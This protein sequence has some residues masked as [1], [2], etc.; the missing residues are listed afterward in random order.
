MVQRSGQWLRIL[1]WA[2]GSVMVAPTG[3]ERRT[4]SVSVGSSMVSCL[5]ST[6]TATPMSPETGRYRSRGSGRYRC[7]GVSL[8]HSAQLDSSL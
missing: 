5:T 8:R 7:G 3:L 6:S 2:V 4:V 1:S